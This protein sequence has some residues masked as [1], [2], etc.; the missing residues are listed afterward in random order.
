MVH[1][2]VCKACSYWVYILKDTLVVPVFAFFFGGSNLSRRITCWQY[3][4]CPF[5]LSLN[6][7]LPPQPI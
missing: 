4:S 1:Q 3:S 2:I 7:A 6:V 5:S